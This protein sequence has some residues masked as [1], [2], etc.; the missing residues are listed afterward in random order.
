PERVWFLF[1][2]IHD[3]EF[4]FGISSDSGLGFGRESFFIGNVVH[5]VHTSGAYNPDTAWSSA[6][7][8]FSGG[9]D[10]Y[11]VNNS[12]FDVDAG[13]NVPG[14]GSVRMVNN[15]LASLTRPEG[16]HVFIERAAT[17]SA[18]VLF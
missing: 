12:A 3:C 13:I 16:A 9:A 11:V 18:S 4:G 1:N 2:H 17:A 6:A 15:I 14:P 8:M 7:F 10:R 5:N